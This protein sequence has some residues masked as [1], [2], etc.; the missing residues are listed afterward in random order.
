MA[1]M[2]AVLTLAGMAAAGCYGLMLSWAVLRLINAAASW[3][4]RR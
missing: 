4:E 3:L 1:D 2:V